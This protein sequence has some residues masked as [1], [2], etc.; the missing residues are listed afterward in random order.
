MARRSAYLAYFLSAAASI[1]PWLKGDSKLYQDDRLVTPRRLD[2][3]I[4]SILESV[5]CNF[6]S[7]ALLALSWLSWIVTGAPKNLKM[8][9]PMKRMVCPHKKSW[10]LYTWPVDACTAMLQHLGTLGFMPD[11]CNYFSVRSS[12]AWQAA[13]PLARREVSS[14]YCKRLHC[15]VVLEGE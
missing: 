11:Q 13:G 1:P 6:F 9:D 5:V 2:S 14:V 7:S 8:L 12:K 3:R 4:A 10:G 15:W